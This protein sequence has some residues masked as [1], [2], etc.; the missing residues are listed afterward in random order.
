MQH[1]IGIPR[2]VSCC[3]WW[4]GFVVASGAK[5]ISLWSRLD[6]YCLIA[7]SISDT[8][9][10]WSILGTATSSIWPQA[11][12]A[13]ASCS[14]TKMLHSAVRIYL[15]YR[16]G[17]LSTRQKTSKIDITPAPEEMGLPQHCRQRKK[18]PSTC[19]KHITG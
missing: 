2:T 9:T 16:V 6:V 12:L 3:C 19:G 18:G 4:F 8:Q 14:D 10:L 17:S 13:A 11:H 5:K 1:C 15:S 7:A